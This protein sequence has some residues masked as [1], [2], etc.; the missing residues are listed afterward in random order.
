LAGG[1]RETTRMAGHQGN[2]ATPHSNLTPMRSLFLLVLAL[3]LGMLFGL[4]RLV[5]ANF[6]CA[7]RS[8]NTNNCTAQ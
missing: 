2:R 7:N 5:Q 3:T 6:P 8:Q 1:A 4:D